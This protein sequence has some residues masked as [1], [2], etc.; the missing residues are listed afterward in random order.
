V[1]NICITSFPPIISF[2]SFVYPC[3]LC[4][5]LCVPLLDLNAISGSTITLSIPPLHLKGACPPQLL[6]GAC[7]PQLLEG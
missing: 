1:S 3:D 4:F 2:N 7:P 6:E 5:P